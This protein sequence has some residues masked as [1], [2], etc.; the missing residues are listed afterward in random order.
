MLETFVIVKTYANVEEMHVVTKDVERVLGE[1][2]EMPLEPLKEECEEGMTANIGLEKHVFAL[3]ESFI[4]K[5]K[6]FSYGVGTIPQ[7]PNSFSVSNIVCQQN[8]LGVLVLV[9]IDIGQ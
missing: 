5:F 9:I 7:I 6:G 3:N 4:K 2:C 8:L 1:L